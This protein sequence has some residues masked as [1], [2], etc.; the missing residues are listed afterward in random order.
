MGRASGDTLAA[1]QS[2]RTGQCPKVGGGIT[3]PLPGGLDEVRVG[4]VVGAEGVGARVR[5]DNLHEVVGFAASVPQQL[6]ADLSA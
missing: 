3:V 6:G 5:R 2:V 4:L 1:S